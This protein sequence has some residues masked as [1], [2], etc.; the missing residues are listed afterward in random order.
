MKLNLA[1]ILL[2]SFFSFSV[3]A[4]TTENAVTPEDQI[5][6]RMNAS[7]KEASTQSTGQKLM[8]TLG[9]VGCLAGVGYY[10]FK[11]KIYANKPGKAQTQIKVLT[12]HYL[13]PKKSLAIIRVAGESMIIGITDQNI[14][15]IK[16]LS[17][18]DDEVP[19]QVPDSF[20]ETM[21]EQMTESE[22]DVDD[23][24]FNGI[25]SNVFQKIKSMRNLQQ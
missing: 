8:L 15:M 7:E 18:L 19:A 3:L 12:Q 4:Q 23:F 14:S 20:G 24:S 11:K 2:L 16:S 5:P 22:M 25:K 13:G 9:L 17:L 21:T 6:L 10:F 1:A